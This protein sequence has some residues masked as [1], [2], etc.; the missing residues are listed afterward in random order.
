MTCSG[1]EEGGKKGGG[2]ERGRGMEREG[3]KND[4]SLNQVHKELLSR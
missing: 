4:F 3:E 1:W 2:R